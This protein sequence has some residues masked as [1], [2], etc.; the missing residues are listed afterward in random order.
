[1]DHAS[2]L[3]GGTEL[4]TLYLLPK[5]TELVKSW[6]FEKQLFN[7]TLKFLPIK[8]CLSHNNTFPDIPLQFNL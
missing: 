2:L 5:G 8:K 6:T 1:M 7:V 4:I 3:F